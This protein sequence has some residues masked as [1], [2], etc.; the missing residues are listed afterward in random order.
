MAT[1]EAISAFLESQLVSLNRDGVSAVEAADWLIEKG[2][3]AG[4]KQPYKHLRFLLRTG[5]IKGAY[6]FPNKRWVIINRSRLPDGIQRVV[7]IKE[8]ATNLRMSEASLRD[9]VSLQ[10]LQRLEFGPSMFL[11]LENE[12]KRYN[13]EYIEK[14]LLLEL[15]PD[16]RRKET[17]LVRLK[18][19]LYYLRS[20]VR[21]IA[22]RIEELIRLLE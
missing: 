11:F 13:R 6:Q 3:L 17:E 22:E 2:L 15:P 1:P 5:K 19:Q 8:A 4:D 20:D 14:S 16:D 21:L 7:P 9:A 18:R 12:L 10:Q